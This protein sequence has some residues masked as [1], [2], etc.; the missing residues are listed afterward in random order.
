MDVEIF[1][2]GIGVAVVFILAFLGLLGVVAAIVNA[3]ESDNK[4]DRSR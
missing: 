2:A 1:F 4:S 3:I